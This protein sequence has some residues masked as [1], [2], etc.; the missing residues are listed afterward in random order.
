VLPAS[1][2][3]PVEV[4]AGTGTVAVRVPALELTRRLCLAAGPLVSTSANVAG[5]RPP[6]TC[7]EAVADL[8]GAVT[9]AL[10]AGPRLGRPSTIVD[11][12]SGAPRLV[13]EGAVPWAEVESVLR[14]AVS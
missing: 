5:R 4:T 1:V 10:D 9:L 11:L 12:S 3:L 14:P 2:A 6:A 7:A 13:R 8:A